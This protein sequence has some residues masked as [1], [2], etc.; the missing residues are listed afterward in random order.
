MEIAVEYDFHSYTL[1]Y[2]IFTF[3]FYF[4][5]ANNL[6]I[7]LNN[8]LYALSNQLNRLLNINLKRRINL[9]NPLNNDNLKT[10]PSVYPNEAYY[11]NA[12]DTYALTTLK[13]TFY[14]LIK[15]Y[16]EEEKDLIFLCIGTDRA[17]GDCLGPLVGHKLKRLPVA[18]KIIVYGSLEQ[19]VHAQNLAKT[20]F[21]IKEKYPNGIIIAIDAC[22]GITKHINHISLGYGSIKPGAGVKKELPEVGDIFITG[23]VN[24]ST[25]MG[26]SILQ[27]T[28]LY[29]VF[30][31]AEIISNAIWL[32]LY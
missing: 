7:S 18:K 5:C 24:S 11:V 30:K 2:H 21:E 9:I 23:I 27:S 6:Y 32:S 4:S 25:I 17:T 1:N 3:I 22:L 8:T 16:I 12:L 19:P 26:F 10:N 15:R 14:S 20:I 13:N 28:R 29:G 31:M